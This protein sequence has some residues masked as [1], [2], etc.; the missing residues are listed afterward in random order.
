MPR[1]RRRNR[2]GVYL[3]PQRLRDLR[4]KSREKMQAGLPLD[5]VRLCRR[6]VTMPMLGGV[7][8]INVAVAA[9][10]IIYHFT[11]LPPGPRQF[12]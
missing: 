4:W 9:G 11:N 6:Q 5:L 2:D 7:D 3:L 1:Q 12:A 10:I 8:S